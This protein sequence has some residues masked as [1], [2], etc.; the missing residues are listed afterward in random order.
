MKDSAIIVK[1]GAIQD[2]AFYEKA[3]SFLIWETTKGNWMTIEE[4]SETLM[5]AQTNGRVFGCLLFIEIEPWFFSRSV[6][7]KASDITPTH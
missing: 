6:A 4:Y 5:K 3:K 7:D 2:T 1:L